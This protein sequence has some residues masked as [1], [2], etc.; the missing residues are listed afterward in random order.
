MD[1]SHL[2]E[3]DTLFDAV[4]EFVINTK[5]CS[6]SLIQ[7][8][9]SIG[10]NR[11]CRIIDQLKEAGVISLSQNEVSYSINMDYPISL[12]NVQH[13]PK[14]TITYRLSF[15]NPQPSRLPDTSK[16]LPQNDIET[17]FLPAFDRIVDK[18]TIKGWLT[19]EEED[20]IHYFII[21]YHLR[22]ESIERRS[23]F[24]ELTK[25][26]IRTRLRNSELPSNHIKTP[27]EPPVILEEG[28]TIIFGF[29]DTEC[30]IQKKL[31]GK[32]ITQGI[33]YFTNERLIFCETES[34]ELIIIVYTNILN[35]DQIPGGIV[36]RIHK[37][38]IA[39]TNIDS[40]FTYNIVSSLILMAGHRIN[41]G[42]I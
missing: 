25:A 1:N 18:F 19:N 6:A 38:K 24:I 27:T 34:R 12:Q 11:S 41:I 28:E 35:I 5:T 15:K 10:Y 16:V 17:I 42:N 8:R 30:C 22:D 14:N 23:S 21:H 4:A 36:I 26:Q 33:L 20:Y 40:D 37:Q 2:F 31:W 9:F 3:F 7:R 39:L 32:Y 29:P 13:N